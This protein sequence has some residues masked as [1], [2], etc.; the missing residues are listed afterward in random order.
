V[1]LGTFHNSE[2]AKVIH[3]NF[4]GHCG[5]VVTSGHHNLVWLANYLNHQ[6]AE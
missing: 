6:L 1:V 3:P 5:V 4:R 2:S